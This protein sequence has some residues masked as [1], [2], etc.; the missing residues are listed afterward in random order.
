MNP[1]TVKRKAIVAITGVTIVL[2]YAIFFM[3]N[4]VTPFERFFR[5]S[6]TLTTPA[7]INAS[8]R[9]EIVIDVV[10]NNLPNREFPA[11]SLSVSFD[12]NFIKFVGIRQGNMMV[13]GN[14]IDSFN[15]PLWH[16]DVEVANTNGKINT[17][18]LDMSGGNHPYI[19]DD[20]ND[21]LL[22]FV[23]RLKDSVSPGEIHHVVIEDVIFAAVDETESIGN[24]LGNLLAFN[25]QIIVK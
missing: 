5:G 2:I 11:A 20:E 13:R 6:V 1:F 12:N 10:T 16:S 23:F 25:A 9:S 17:M 3:N 21:I 22:R 4:E 18:Y 15:I 19:I 7:A 14:T 24:G 8:D